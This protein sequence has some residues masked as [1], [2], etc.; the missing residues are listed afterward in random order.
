MLG[1]SVSLAELSR[2]IHG[3]TTLVLEHNE[4]DRIV[5]YLVGPMH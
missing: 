2:R 1:V 3:T 5:A 4:Y